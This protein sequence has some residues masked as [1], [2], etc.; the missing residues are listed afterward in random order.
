MRKRTKTGPMPGV[1]VHGV[2]TERPRVMLPPEPGDHDDADTNE[3]LGKPIHGH[4]IR[5]RSNKE[6]SIHSNV[7]PKPVFPIIIDKKADINFTSSKTICSQ[8]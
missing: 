5:D 6:N 1:N 4:V 3:C 2:A 8:S 7:N